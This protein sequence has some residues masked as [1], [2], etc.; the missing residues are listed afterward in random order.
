M[1]H[2]LYLGFT[3]M[4]EILKIYAQIDDFIHAKSDEISSNLISFMCH[5]STYK[6]ILLY[7]SDVFIAAC[8]DPIIILHE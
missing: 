4:I 2:L 8:Y 3:C 1:F 7:M 5:P 6:F